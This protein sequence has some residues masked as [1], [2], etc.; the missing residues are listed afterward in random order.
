MKKISI[1]IL[2][3]RIVSVLFGLGVSFLFFDMIYTYFHHKMK[4]DRLFVWVCVMCVSGILF[5]ILWNKIKSKLVYLLLF[6]PIICIA[7]EIGIEIYEEHIDQKMYDEYQKSVKNIPAVRE[8]DS[9]LYVVRQE[10]TLYGGY[11]PFSQDNLLAKL[12]EKSSFKLIDNLPILDGATAFYPVYASFVQ[13]VYPQT[14]NNY[15]PYTG[16][17]LCSRTEK[18]YENLLEGKV[19]MIF[20]LEPSDLQLKYFYDNG[21]K[22]KL[23]PIGKEAFVFF[24]NK[25]NPVNNLTIGNIRDIYSGKVTNWNK[26]NG[27]DQDIM[28]F[29]RPKNSGSQTMLEKIMGNI[30]IIEPQMEYVAVAMHRIIDIVADYRNFPNAIGYSFLQFS[31]EM[32]KNDQIKLLSIDGI[33]PSYQAIQDGSYPFSENFYAVYIDSDQKNEN[34]DLFIVWILSR[35]GQTLVSK[36]GYIPM[37]IEQ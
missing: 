37:N 3:K 22:L 36:T 35:Q 21:Y 4:I 7:T 20:C 5:L 16:I 15:S 1:K 29:Q 33:F 10:D 31:T 9:A 28:A 18:A 14:D 17:V 27:V 13:A 32:V 11:R 25:E 24:V 23:I 12:D 34:I 8:R 6:V 2:V 26:L 19:D 30:S